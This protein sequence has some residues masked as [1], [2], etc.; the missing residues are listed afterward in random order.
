MNE[1]FVQAV[2]KHQLF[3]QQEFKTTNGQSIRVVHPGT[4][5]TDAGPDFNSAKVFIDN[6]LW[7][8]NVEI[9]VHSSDWNKHHH[10]TDSAYNNVILHV[11][12]ID[13]VEFCKTANDLLLTTLVI[14]PYLNSELVENYQLLLADLR[15]IPCKHWWLRMEE[16]IVEKWLERMCVSRYEQKCIL[17]RERLFALNGHWDQL[18][19]EILSR[20]LG[21]F[22]NAEPME[23]L[24]Q[25][26]KT[27]WIQKLAYQPLSIEALLFGQAGMLNRNFDDNYPNE[28]KNEYAYLQKKYNIKP[29][30]NTNWK[31]SRLRPSNFPTIR[32]AQ[33]AAILIKHPRLF[34]DCLNI[35]K[36]KDAY[37]FFD[38]EVYTYWESHYTFDRETKEKG[39]KIGQDSIEQI[40]LN[41]L[42][43]LWILYAN[44]KGEEVY[45]EKAFDLMEILKPEENRFVKSF[46]ETQFKF[47]N[48]IHSQG[49]RFLKE[50]YCDEKKCLTCSIGI[51]GLKL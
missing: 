23:Q 29:I 19:F 16:P 8:G 24:A 43:L 41:T 21:F 1:D 10:Y 45:L 6:L 51:N 38:V 26:I 36:A 49:L 30:V 28:L 33:L 40:L 22:V 20:Q 18:F 35:Q 17:L 9:H 27:E 7:V 11:V 3:N 5:N 34:S 25:S 32:I 4:L 42:C 2:W 13:D 12:Y 50:N 46:A 37:H 39:K 44:V 15:E 48:S 14:K 31:F 47:R